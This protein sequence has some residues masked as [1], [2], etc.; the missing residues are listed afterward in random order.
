VIRSG[1]EEGEVLVLSEPRP[2]VPGLK[3]EPVEGGRAAAG[4]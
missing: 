1:L 2:P 3:L 4:R